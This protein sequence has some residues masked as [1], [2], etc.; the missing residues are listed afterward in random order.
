MLHV[1]V[2][3][4]MVMFSGMG[5]ASWQRFMEADGDG[6]LVCVWE[7][8][9]GPGDALHALSMSVEAPS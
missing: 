9:G 5:A 7:W 8:K 4:V 3:H 2:M 6:M 1:M